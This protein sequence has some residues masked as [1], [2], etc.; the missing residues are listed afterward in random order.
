[1]SNLMI[2][3]TKTYLY[4]KCTNQITI[5]R[6]TEITNFIRILHKA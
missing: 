5:L 4:E 6:T 3:A 2:Q 1:M